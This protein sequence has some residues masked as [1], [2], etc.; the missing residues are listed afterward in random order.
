[1]TI[2]EIAKCLGYNSKIIYKAFEETSKTD[3]EIGK[4]IKAKSVT[5]KKNMSVDYSFEEANFA[6]KTLPTYTQMS[7]QYLKENFIVH[8]D[9]YARRESVKA[10][11][12][13]E[14]KE[15][16]D[17]YFENHTNLC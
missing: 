14:A 9:G 1:M 13:K 7:H 11:I 6:L 3:T 10:K 2:N 17:T 5:S 16:I 12:P 8:S 15:F 4:I